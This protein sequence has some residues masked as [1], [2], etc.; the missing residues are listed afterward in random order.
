[1]TDQ[2]NEGYRSRQQRP[3][4]EVAQR[5]DA[6]SP[7]PVAPQ[8]QAIERRKA[9]VGRVAM[10]VKGAARDFD[11]LLP[12]HIGTATFLSAAGAALWKSEDLMEGAIQDPEAFLIALRESASLGHLPGT[13]HYWLT[14]RR[15]DRRMSVL[16]I[17]GYQGIVERM[18]RSGGVLSVHA[19]IVRTND[20]FEPYA[21]PNGRPLH[22]F[23]GKLGAFSTRAER[24]EVIGT[25]AYAMLPGG[26]PSQ[27]V[28]LS[29]EDLMELKAASDSA[30]SK[31]SPWNKWPL[32]MYL[33][34]ALRRLEPYVPVSAGYRTASVQAQAFVAA[35]APAVLPP[36]M[37]D[38]VQAEVQPDDGAMEG[39]IVD[40][41]DRPVTNVPYDPEQWGGD[42][43]WEGLSK[44][45]PVQPQQ[46]GGDGWDG[47][48]VAQPGQGGP[49]NG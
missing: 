17:E 5:S 38:D 16:G 20:T 30:T 9:A 48:P 7:E 26:F 42:P 22:Q 23:G 19:E 29:F 47:I 32:R 11:R 41:Q 12:E 24:G 10:T 35:T 39:Q 1:M 4:G 28:L 46:Q 40:S 2:N 43:A 27:A 36:R 14:P 44:T 33:K 37:E 6:A 3:Q 15:R 49:I 13:D 8:I 31:W 45:R 34:S 25:Y 18:Y 21:G